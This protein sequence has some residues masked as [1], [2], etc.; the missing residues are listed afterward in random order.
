MKLITGLL[1][2]AF[3]LG[4]Y[5]QQETVLT[6]QDEL[7]LTH[8][9]FETLMGLNRGQ[10][11]SYIYRVTRAVLDSHMETY[12]FIFVNGAEAREEINSLQPQNP[13]QEACINQWRNRFELQKQRFGQR[14]ARCLGN[15]H[16]YLSTWNTVVNG[17]H[18]NGQSQ[19]S[20]VQNIGF[21]LFARTTVYDGPEDFAALMKF[22]LRDSIFRILGVVDQVEEFISN[23]SINIGD[24]EFDFVRCDKE[25]E[26]AVMREIQ[27]EV[28]GARACV[29]AGGPTDPLPTN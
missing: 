25:L 9:F 17:L 2:F 10:L 8:R 24:I 29:G 3:A 13:G 26:D 23:I 15:V 12:E 7:G 1:V 28:D 5:S 21:N 14:L 4:A 6:V 18:G 19:A 11:S 22:D 20:Q 16:N 27:L